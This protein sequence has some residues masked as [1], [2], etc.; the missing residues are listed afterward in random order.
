MVENKQ[1][2]M[3]AVDLLVTIVTSVLTTLILLH[4]LK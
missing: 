3:T 2:P 4:F 1:T